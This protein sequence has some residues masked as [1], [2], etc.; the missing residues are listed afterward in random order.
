I[1]G[2]NHGIPSLAISLH[3]DQEF[4]FSKGVKVDFTLAKRALASISSTMLKKGLPRGVDLLN[5]NV[6]D[7][8]VRDVGLKITRLAHRMY[9]ARVQRLDAPSGGSNY[10]IDGDAI[11][12][13]EP[14]TDV[15][16]VRVENCISVTPLSLDFT[17]HDEIK[18]LKFKF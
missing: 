8:N 4:R 13:A 18:D 6:P 14:S 11:F 2:A 12:D 7:S 9:S 16:A 10:I 15:Y 17:A 3:L 1:E 5:I